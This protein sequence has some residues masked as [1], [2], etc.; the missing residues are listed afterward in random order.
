MKKIGNRIR[1]FFYR[2][3]DKGIPNL[4]LYVVLGSGLVSIMD[5]VL[6]GERLLSSY[7]RFDKALI[8]KGQLWRLF[9]YIFTENSGNYIFMTLIFLY[10]FYHLGRRVELQMGTLRFNA[11]YLSGVL[12]MDLFAMIFCPTTDVATAW[13][14][15]PAW[16]FNAFYGNMAWYLHLSILLMF[17]VTNPDAKFLILFFIPVSAWFM[18]IVYLVLVS[19][20]ILNYIKL[21]PHN[22]FPLAGLMNFLLFAGKDVRNLLP[23]LSRRP[24]RQPAPRKPTGSVPFRK[25]SPATPAYNHRCTICGRTDVSDPHLEFRYCSRCN[26]YFCYC[27]DHINNHE[28]VQ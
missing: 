16:Y 18:G 21:F 14:T 19:I 13:G 25:E 9:T 28:H 15:I 8:L 17:A 3:Q 11:F 1:M 2:N 22:L 5:L 26:G 4:M 7:L 24:R 6:G 10:F 27:E 20:D 12:M 23:F